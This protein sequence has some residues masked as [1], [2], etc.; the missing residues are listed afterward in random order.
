MGAQAAILNIAGVLLCA[1]AMI[2]AAYLIH[3]AAHQTL[4]SAHW[5]NRIAGEAMNFIAGSCYASFERIRHMHIRHHVDR[6][7]VTCFDF[8]GLMRRRPGVRRVLQILEWAYVPA[9]E[10]LMHLQVIWRP[11]FVRSQRK[12]L[13]RVAAMLVVRSLL[14]ALLGLWSWKALLLYVVAT[15]LLLHVL[16]FFD[17]FHHTFEQYFVA[18]DEPVSM[19]GRDRRY[20]LDHT[21]SNLISR[22]H[23]WLNLLTLNFGYH[24]AHHH[25]PSVPWYRLPAFHGDLYGDHTRAVLP[26][27]ELLRTWHR[28]R[29]RRVSSDDYGAP[30]DGR[31]RADNFIGAHGVSFLTVM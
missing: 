3:E 5:A 25:R 17:A 7:D 22:R 27:S 14:L 18:A 10:T 23:P 13:L 20:E 9:T 26:L 16:N 21:Y 28:N 4:F 24:N 2:L 31:G 19:E 29:V 15:A 12:H 8:K 6:A 30:G 11:F 1:H